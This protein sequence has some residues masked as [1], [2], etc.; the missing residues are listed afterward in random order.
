MVK[1]AIV[2][3]GIAGLSAAFYLKDHA[4]IT[5]LSKGKGASF[6]A[7]GLMHKFVGDTGYKSIYADEAFIDSSAI[8]EMFDPAFYQ[9]TKILR[10][11]LTPEMK[12]VFLKYQGAD[13]DFLD[14]DYVVIKEGYL[15]DVPK[16]LE[17]LQ[18]LLL[19]HQVKFIEKEIE[20]YEDFSGFDFVIICAGGGIKQLCPAL[21]MKY[22]KGQAFV[23][24]N[25]HHHHL[26][27][28]AKGYL[29]PF[30]DKVVI[31]STYEKKFVNQ[32]PDFEIAQQYLKEPLKQYFHPYETQEVVEILAGIR[33]FHP[34]YN[35]PKIIK[36]NDKTLIVTGL[37]SRGL[38]YHGFL[39]S[40]LRDI[41]IYKKTSSVFLL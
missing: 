10:K 20:P 40:L 27:L 17:K 18:H 41:L 21:K 34:N 30:S 36:K 7:A 28:I 8:L 15:I 24:Q 2:G 39:G 25:L 12:E 29:A 38:L 22:L 13:L 5:L 16:Y 32:E 33:V 1:I 6:A 14:D 3:A 37:G 4:H 23:Y 9:K 31:G 11:I 19:L 35:H 26:P